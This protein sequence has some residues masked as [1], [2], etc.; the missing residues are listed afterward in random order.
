LIEGE[1]EKN[2][3]E[4]AEKG[5]VKKFHQPSLR[6]GVGRPGVMPR[7]SLG[8]GV[9]WSSSSNAC[10]DDGDLSLLVYIEAWS[11]SKFVAVE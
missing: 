9:S 11:S 10:E 3:P 1:R 2:E 8:S 4:R 7:M 5:E 6:C